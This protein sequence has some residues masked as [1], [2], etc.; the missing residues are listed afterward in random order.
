MTNKQCQPLT[1]SLVF[2]TQ[3]NRAIQHNNLHTT[4]CTFATLLKQMM[5]T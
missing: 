4:S 2:Q 3:K 5:R 1:E